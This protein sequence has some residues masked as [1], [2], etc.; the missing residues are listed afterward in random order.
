MIFKQIFRIAFIA[1]IWKQYKAWI[2]STTLLL[3]SLYLIGQVH[4]DLLQHWEIQQDTSQTGSSFIY[5]WLS[6]VACTGLY[7][8]YHYVRPKKSSTDQLKDTKKK[9]AKLKDELNK[10]SG[11]DDPFNEIRN[12]KK[13]RSRSDFILD[14]EN[15]NKKHK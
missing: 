6:Y 15:T 3:L 2:I 9:Q 5:K 4:R 14:S 7:G 10:L 8:L 12:R 13:L 1:L 11:D